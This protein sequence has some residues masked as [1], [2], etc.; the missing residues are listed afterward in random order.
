MSGL[1]WKYFLE[2]NVDRFKDL[3]ANGYPNSQH[4]S[5][6]HG[7]GAG[8]SGSLGSH[9][10]CPETGFGISPRVTPKSKKLPGY[11]GI[12]G[13]AKAQTNMPTRGDLNS[14]D[15][16]GL[17]I[18][19]RAVS[20]TGENALGFAMALIE[21]PAV[22]IYVQDRENGWTALHRALYFGNVTVA[23]A[24]MDRDWRESTGQVARNTVLGT[25]PLVKI[26][27]YEGNSA[28]DVY[29]ATVAHRTL[30]HRYLP[31]N[32]SHE[33]EE[34]K[35]SVSAG[36]R[37]SNAQGNDNINGD[38]VFAF[39]SN[40]NLTLGFGDEDDRQHPERVTLK[41]PDHL[42]FR[43]YGD[44]L[45]SAAISGGESRG[46]PAKVSRSKKALLFSAVLNFLLPTPMAKP[47]WTF[48]NYKIIT[49]GHC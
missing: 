45:S 46:E 43:F 35:S 21:H 32:S 38:E 20:I 3:L 26:K 27:D 18:L 1:L 14:R 33:G 41:R 31:V 10:E 6:G 22:D 7:G 23:R 16:S 30:Q 42:L 2:G 36:D 40:K 24:L 34:D 17:T 12:I 47:S 48:F 11:S 15:Q 5:K 44:Y 28:F 29:N 37:D 19:H 25:S 39:G 13:T 49:V 9:V 4:A 8:Q